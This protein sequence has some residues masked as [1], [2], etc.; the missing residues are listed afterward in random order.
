MKISKIEALH[1]LYSAITLKM[2]ESK[3]Q[4]SDQ[5]LLKYIKANYNFIDSRLTYYLSVYLINNID[6]LIN[7]EISYDESSNAFIIIDSQK[8][9]FFA[10]IISL[11]DDSIL[12]LRRDTIKK[13]QKSTT[14]LTEDGIEF[15]K[16]Y[17]TKKGNN[18][19]NE[20]I[21]PDNYEIFYREYPNLGLVN[22]LYK[23]K[24]ETKIESYMVSYI[25]PLSLSKEKLLRFQESQKD[26][27]EDF[28]WKKYLENEKNI[29]LPVY[30]KKFFDDTYNEYQ[31]YLSLL[32]ST[33]DTQIYISKEILEKG[34]RSKNP[35]Y[36][37]NKQINNEIN[38]K[39]EIKTVEISINKKNNWTNHKRNK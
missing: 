19:E 2:S 29:F 31:Y 18:S 32:N 17:E 5:E 21:T 20:I 38:I 15:V 25:N 23:I 7:T 34:I 36:N 39:P 37:L 6:D 24:E 8:N 26:N 14:F 10:E 28:F 3:T 4:D 33:S 27:I 13:N 22:H 12:E 1:S 11:N 30:A 35:Y 16:I 9:N